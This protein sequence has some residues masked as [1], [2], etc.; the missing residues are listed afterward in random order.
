M[1]VQLVLF[2]LTSAIVLPFGINYVLGPQAFGDPVRVHA[3]MTDALGLTAGTSVTYRG[4]WS[5]RWRGCRSTP[6]SAVP[7]WSS[8]WTRGP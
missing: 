2:A 7:V 4:S 3:T 1:L 6:T 5:G 8:T